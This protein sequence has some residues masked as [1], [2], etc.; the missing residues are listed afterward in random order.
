[1]EKARTR[2]L[3]PR[4]SA[5]QRRTVKIA[6]PC[7]VSARSTAACFR[8]HRRPQWSQACGRRRSAG[9]TSKVQEKSLVR[10][11]RR[12]H[13]AR[14]PIENRHRGHCLGVWPCREFADELACPCRRIPRGNCCG[15]VLLGSD[16][17]PHNSTTEMEK[18]SRAIEAGRGNA[19]TPV[20]E[21]NALRTSANRHECAAVLLK[22]PNNVTCAPPLDAASLGSTPLILSPAHA[23][24]VSP[25]RRRRGFPRE[26]RPIALACSAFGFAPRSRCT[27]FTMHA[28]GAAD[29][30]AQHT[31][32]R[33]V[34]QCQREP[35]A[36]DCSCGFAPTSYPA[37][38]VLLLAAGGRWGCVEPAG[39]PTTL[40]ITA[41]ATRAQNPSASLSRPDSPPAGALPGR[42]VP[43]L[44]RVHPCECADVTHGRSVRQQSRCSRRP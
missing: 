22:V 13:A 37:H 30:A 18:S 35:Q 34:C 9:G 42:L 31:L 33:H 1:M 41:S 39:A 32:T 16:K 43:R 14:V 5:A 12:K 8:G 17:G 24:G 6:H 27:R 19:C 28:H 25:S 20:I 3:S 44:A 21:F 29:K 4:D 2:S 10:G 11:L 23:C 15:T 40:F 7:S 26:L 38:G 36:D